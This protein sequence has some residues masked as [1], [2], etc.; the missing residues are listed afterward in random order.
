MVCALPELKDIVR[1]ADIR[2]GLWTD[3][4]IVPFDRA[5]RPVLCR[6]LAGGMFRSEPDGV[7]FV[8][9]AIYRVNRQWEHFVCS[10]HRL[11]R[12]GGL[13]LPDDCS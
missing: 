5:G 10:A 13:C 4:Y 9:E 11:R 1:G 6:D 3:Q 8:S 12:P 7:S 2:W